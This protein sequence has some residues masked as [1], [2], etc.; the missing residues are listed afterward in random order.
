MTVPVTPP[1]QGPAGSLI[2]TGTAQVG[3]TLTVDTSGITDGNGISG[4]FSYTWWKQIDFGP[5]ADVE[6]QIS[7]AY[8]ST[9]Q[10]RR[11]DVRAKIWAKVHYTDDDGFNERKTSDFTAKVIPTADEAPYVISMHLKV[12]NGPII[13][14][15]SSFEVSEGHSFDVRVFMSKNV[16][17]IT[18]A[19]YAPRMRLNIGGQTRILP[20]YINSQCNFVSPG[21]C[22]SSTSELKF[23]HN[24]E[25]GDTGTITFPTNGMFISNGQ[26][27]TNPT[28]PSE[29]NFVDT[30]LNY[31]RKNLG[32]VTV[33]ASQNQVQEPTISISNATATE[34]TDA[35]MS[36]DVTLDQPATQ[37]VTVDWTTVDGTATAGSDYTAGSGTLTFA[38]GES[39]KTITI[40]I[41]D[42]SVN[43]GSETFLVN[44]S[45]VSGAVISDSQGEGTINNTETVTTPVTASFQDLPVEHD[46]SSNFI[47]RVKISESLRPRSKRSIKDALT[48]IN[49]SLQ[50]VQTVG[51]RDNWR[52]TVRPSSIAAV[53]ISFVPKTDCSNVLAPCTSDD[54]A[55]SSLLSTQ[56]MGPPMISINDASAYENTDTS[57]SFSVTLNRPAIQ[58]VTVGWAT[59]DGTATAGSDYT[60]DSGTL[61][62]AS[63]ESS[64]TITIALLN[65]SVDEG[66][67]TFYVNLS[68]ASGAQIADGAA[69]GT[70]NNTDAMPKAWISRFGRTVGNQAMDAISAQMGNF[71]SEKQLVIGG[72]EVSSNENLSE[73][74]LMA[75]IRQERFKQGNF[76]WTETEREAT[77]EMTLQEVIHGTSF[78]LSGQSKET[79]KQSW[80]TWG[81]VS[82]NNFN[83]KE[84]NVNLEAEVTSGFFG[85]DL[86]SGNWKGGLALSQSESKGTFDLLDENS[87]EDRGN[88]KSSLTSLFP[89][90]GYEFGENQ[91]VWGILGMG[92][93]DITL[94]Q[95]ANEERERDERIKTDISMRM[96]AVGAK[97]PLLKQSEGETADVTLQADGMYLKMK[98]EKT[99]GMESSE[100]DV[101]QLRLF[102]DSSKTIELEKGTLTP[103]FQV[104]MRHD[105]GDAEEGLG[106][107]AGGTLRYEAGSVTIE[108]SVRKLVAHESDHEEWGASAALRVDPG[109]SGRGLNLSVLPTWGEPSSG[110]NNLLSVE[111]PRQLGSNSFE[112]DNRLE[113]EIG[114][115]VFNPFKKLIG[116]LTPY[117]ALSLGDTNRV[118][119]TGTRWKI[120]H[121]A[122]LGLELSR[123]KGESKESDDKAIRLRGGFQW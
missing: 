90:L 43:E 28:P 44:L 84:E 99:T 123:T 118:T 66:S 1:N 85:A 92:E 115:G 82:H 9:Y 104:G 97:G 95:K 121:N 79:G 33:L 54:R 17:G 88:V 86:K 69:T 96:G 70:I 74:D 15:G 36:F 64:K 14:P 27:D 42:D 78:Y 57:I 91:A 38:Q 2:I 22:P 24:V 59:A 63:G 114:Y 31:P 75:Q 76:N 35:S 19:N 117:F 100:A 30:D 103:S 93:G 111:G 72:V 113:A 105:G 107:E 16:T 53:N 45:N 110:V 56:V 4:S 67:E 102:V 58:S 5:N 116:V 25:A 94:T 32:Y 122:N 29:A 81:Q 52:V 6:E 65:D 68:N 3:E 71:S 40:A 26:G 11:E 62:F 120:S 109:Q 7:G 112:A 98:S 119:R 87:V 23:F 77:Q 37:T 41:L 49:G 20:W 47:F 12:L 39:S 34:N 83:G 89:Y 8:S 48:V 73:E 101:T 51:S 61:T 60:A 108:G 50:K 10:I 21:P 18:S 80:S 46:G 13:E 55:V 106:L